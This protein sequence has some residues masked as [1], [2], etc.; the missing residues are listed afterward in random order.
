[1]LPSAG[2]QKDGTLVLRTHASHLHVACSINELQLE[3][4][5]GLC[6]GSRHLLPRREDALFS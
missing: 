3:F 6:W 2:L 5:W 1:M 4:C